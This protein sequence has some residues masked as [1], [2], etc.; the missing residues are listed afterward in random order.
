M[1][2][3]SNDTTTHA[4]EIVTRYLAAADRGDSTS[5]ADCFVTDGTVIDE[6]REYVGRPAIKA[7][8][9]ALASQF[10]YTRTLTGSDAAGEST[11]LIRSR[12]KG[13]FPGG[14]ADLT[15]TF[16]IEDGLIA[17]LHIG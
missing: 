5:A 4:P 9:D 1:R 15:Y 8:R 13:D 17:A 16:T 11:Y 14:V 6:G 12:L 2:R 10:T 3:M 7:W